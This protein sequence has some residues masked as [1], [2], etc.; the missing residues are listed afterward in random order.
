MTDEE[1]AANAFA[2]ELMKACPHVPKA[3][4]YGPIRCSVC[5]GEF[6]LLLKPRLAR[7]IPFTVDDEE[8]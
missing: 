6:A 7:P 2:N 4:P 5:G 1:D 3:T 8:S